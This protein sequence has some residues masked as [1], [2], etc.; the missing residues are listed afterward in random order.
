MLS[1]AI[2]ISNCINK[3]KLLRKKLPSLSNRPNKYTLFCIKNIHKKKMSLFRVIMKLE[4]KKFK[5]YIMS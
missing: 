1:I 5:I 2:R 3:S 4:K